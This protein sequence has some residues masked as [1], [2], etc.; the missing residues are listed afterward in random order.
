L[1][2]AAT[3][4]HLFFQK[5]DAMP[6]FY[7]HNNSCISAQQTFAGIDLDTVNSVIDNKLQAAEPDYKGIPAGV[8]RR[9][10][11]AVRMGVGAALP[12]VANKQ[13][14]GV[15][16]G[17]ANGGMEDCIKFLNQLIDYDEG[18]LTPGNFVQSTP[19]AVAAQIGLINRCKAYN[20]THTHGGLSFE[21][22]LL[23]AA[24]MLKDNPA[25]TYL[26]GG[27]DEISTYNYNID[28]LAGWYK[29]DGFSN[30]L[31]ATD[32][33]GSIAGE[34]AVMFMANNSPENAQ[35][36]IDAMETF[37][38]ADEA[39]VQQRI[40]QFIAKQT[41][42]TKFLDVLLT[43]ENGDSRFKQ[44][45]NV[46]EGL[47]PPDT[48]VAR[49]KHFSG[50]FPTSSAVALWLAVHFLQSQNIPA[51]FIKQ[52]RGEKGFKKILIYNHFKEVQH[53]LMLVSLPV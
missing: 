28:F 27:F 12:V 11:K 35:A 2:L 20:I 41:T 8:L 23:D 4:P 19:N 29:K 40:Q 47:V 51:H 48:T 7:L 24:M 26:V 53:S 44:Y 15:I 37:H 9:M 49:Y 43:G 25:A 42:K 21:N 17:T 13:L 1:A 52:A 22:A 31:Y 10:G 39:V 18:M 50:E 33:A 5:P 16:I 46:C 45:Y 6:L 34:G 30:N 32:S 14:D 3:A 36:Q 38:T